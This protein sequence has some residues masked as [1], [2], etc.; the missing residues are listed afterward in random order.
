MHYLLSLY[1]ITNSGEIS[2]P[3]SLRSSSWLTTLASSLKRGCVWFHHYLFLS[4]GIIN[5][6]Q[7]VPSCKCNCKTNDMSSLYEFNCLSFCSCKAMYYLL[8]VATTLSPFRQEHWPTRYE[9]LA[10][11]SKN[12]GMFNSTAS[13]TCSRKN[14]S[15]PRMYWILDRSRM[16]P[17][18]QST[19][20][21]GDS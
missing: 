1:C 12:S 19:F 14:K 7:L 15:D 6:V 11:A 5:M 13:L 18:V 9:F 16:V 8:L 3:I 20:S 2:W 21:A 17:M 10:H 4:R